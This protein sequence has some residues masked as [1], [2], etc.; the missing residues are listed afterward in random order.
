MNRIKKEKS[1]RLIRCIAILCAMQ[2]VLGLGGCGDGTSTDNSTLSASETAAVSYSYTTAEYYVERG[3][4]SCTLTAPHR[5]VSS[6][7]GRYCSLTA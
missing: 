3:A 5:R 1:T 2:T 6:P 7:K 4:S